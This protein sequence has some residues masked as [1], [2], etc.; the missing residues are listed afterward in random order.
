M[1]NRVTTFTLTITKRIVSMS[2]TNVPEEKSVRHSR[3]YIYFR[4][5]KLFISLF[6][7]NLVLRKTFETNVAQKFRVEQSRR[8]FH[9]Q[10]TYSCSDSPVH[11]LA[12]SVF[13]FPIHSVL[14][15]RPHHEKASCIL[16]KGFYQAGSGPTTEVD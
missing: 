6:N 9:G 4:S 14:P 1:Y 12:N 11:S 15:A 8:N 5:T 7:E 2:L 10:S 3:F 13:L 16:G